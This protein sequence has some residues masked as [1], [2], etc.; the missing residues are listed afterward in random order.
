MNTKPTKIPSRSSHY[1]LSVPKQQ[2]GA[3]VG[4]ICVEFLPLNFDT[5][6]KIALFLISLF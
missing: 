2:Y 4:L 5:R 6:V 1:T 3:K